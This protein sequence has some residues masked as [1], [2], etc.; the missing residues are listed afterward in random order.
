LGCQS[1]QT[2]WIG[3]RVFFCDNRKFTQGWRYYNYSINVVDKNEL[4]PK[5]QIFQ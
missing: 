4:F 2:I 5:H 3:S 1:G